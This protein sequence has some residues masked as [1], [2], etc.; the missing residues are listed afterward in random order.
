MFGTY[1]PHVIYFGLKNAPPFFQW[2]MYCKFQPL[3][4]KYE[5]YLLNYLDDWIITTLGGEEGLALY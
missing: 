2:M 5:A 3:V 4:Q 1:V